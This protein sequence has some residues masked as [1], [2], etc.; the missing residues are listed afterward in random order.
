M[1]YNCN[2]WSVCVLNQTPRASLEK[3]DL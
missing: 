2:I 1:L 3:I